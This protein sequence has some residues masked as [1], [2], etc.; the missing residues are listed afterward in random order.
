MKMV[1]HAK[2]DADNLIQ[3]YSQWKENAEERIEN[4]KSMNMR[5]YRVNID[6]DEMSVWFSDN[7][8]ENTVESREAYVDY[9]FQNFMKDPIIK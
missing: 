9:K 8:L 5:V 2:D 4:M 1:N 3:S 7:N 6:Y